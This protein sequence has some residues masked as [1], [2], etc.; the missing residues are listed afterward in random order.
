M[1][2]GKKTIE[3]VLGKPIQLS[4]IEIAEQEL[5]RKM[6]KGK[7]PWNNEEVPSI[8]LA[9]S[10]CREIARYTTFELESE[11]TGAGRGEYLQEQYEKVLDETLDSVAA[12]A[13]GGKVIFKPFV[14]NERILVKTV[15]PECYFPLKY[16]EIGELV[17]V[18]FT[19]R[20][21]RDTYY[22]TLLESHSW[23]ETANTYT[24]T[25]K[26]YKSSRESQ[27]GVPVGLDIIPEWASLQPELNFTNITRPLFV[28]AKMLEG[29]AA[30]SEAIELIKE[31]DEQYGKVL[32]EY[33]GGELAIDANTDLFR[34]TK[35]GKWDLPKGKERLF[36]LNSGDNPKIG[37]DAWAPELRDAAFWRGLNNHLRRIEFAIGFAY[38]ILSDPNEVEKT[39]E[40]IKASKHRFFVTIQEVQKALRKAYKALI[41]AMNML[42]DIYGLAPAGVYEFIFN[43]GDGIMED[44]D[45]EYARR[46]SLA[47]QGYI[48]PKKLVAYAMGLSEEQAEELILEAQQALPHEVIE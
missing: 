13:G 4:Q 36:R 48:H 20:L 3:Q 19:D 23:D 15:T 44:F 9:K 16:N 12:L 10:I 40:E 8:R 18:A 33:L 42:A 35:W 17:S 21:K 43:P 11:I 31:A 37:M 41:E 6:L 29:K 45:K 46:M 34:K 7:A 2:L 39:A 24:I 27:I 25:Y 32:W 22:L 5:W 14:R 30:F 28:E 1:I 38:G 47:S 26:A